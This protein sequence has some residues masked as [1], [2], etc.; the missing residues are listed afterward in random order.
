MTTR[1]PTEPLDRLIAEAQVLAGAAHP[2]ALLGHQWVSIGG[3]NCGCEW[4]EDGEHCRGQC[5]VPV[6]E[7][8]CGDCDYGDNDEAN[9]KR[10]ACAEDRA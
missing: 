8:F 1:E 4:V 7:C 3:A 10:S 6:Y 9:K 2:C 5:S